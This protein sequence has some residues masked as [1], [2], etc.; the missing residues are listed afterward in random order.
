MGGHLKNHTSWQIKGAAVLDELI[1]L[2][3]LSTEEA[4][5]LGALEGAAAARGPQMAE[6][7]YGRLGVHANAVEFIEG[8]PMAGLYKTIIEWFT[9]LFGGSYD[10]A[11]AARRLRIG[12]VHVKIGLPVRYPLAMLDVVLPHGVA[13]ASISPS[14]AAAQRAFF[15][16]LALDAAIFN[17]AYEDNQLSHLV[18]L[19][20]GEL[21]ARRLLA[22]EG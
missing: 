20:G 14:P 2:M 15:K 9:Q 11:Y 7:F 21:L 19:V 5:L 3:N 17:Q 6:E 16:V 10:A 22:G 12:E 4:Q 8:V 13:V 1:T 18:D